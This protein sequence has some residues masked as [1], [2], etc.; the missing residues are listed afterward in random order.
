MKKIL[1][2]M[3]FCLVPFE[4]LAW[5]NGELLIWTDA[6]RGH[7]ITSN[8]GGLSLTGNPITA[9]AMTGGLTKSEVNHP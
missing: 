5:T 3:V 1:I 7:R 6:E 4:L 9:R 8:A 2:L